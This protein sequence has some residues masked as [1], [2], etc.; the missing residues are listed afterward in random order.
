MNIAM[1]GAGR[2]EFGVIM[3]N[4]RNQLNSLGVPVVLG[5]AVTPEF[6]LEQNPDAVIVA[7]GSIAEETRHPGRRQPQGL[8]RLAG[9]QR[10]SGHRGEGALHR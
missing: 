10:R 8:D 4:E 7:T 6:V 2:E 1:K 5:Q 3:R 9:A